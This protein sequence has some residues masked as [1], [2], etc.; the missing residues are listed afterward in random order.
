VITRNS[1]GRWIERAVNGVTAEH[2]TEK[3]DFGG[4]K[5]PHAEGG[6]IPLLSD[7]VELMPER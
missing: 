2:A 4:Q 1:E 3:Q 6:S 5:Q 7:V